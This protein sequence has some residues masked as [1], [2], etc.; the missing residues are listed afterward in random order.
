MLF[1]KIFNFTKEIIVT[2]IF[3]V[4]L[5]W[6]LFAYYFLIFRTIIIHFN[7]FLHSKNTFFERYE[8]SFTYLISI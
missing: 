2:Q 3:Y 6:L 1:E 7:A 8:Y 4:I 5:F